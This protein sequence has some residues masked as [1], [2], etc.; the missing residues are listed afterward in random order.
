MISEKIVDQRKRDAWKMGGS[1]TADPCAVDPD[2]A[3]SKAIFYSVVKATPPSPPP[4][5]KC[6]KSKNVKLITHVQAAE[7]VNPRRSFAEIAERGAGWLGC[8]VGCV[9]VCVCVGGGGGGTDL[10]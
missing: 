10:F 8:G 2:S 3:P 5:A 4:A 9:C 1:D 7:D 6:K